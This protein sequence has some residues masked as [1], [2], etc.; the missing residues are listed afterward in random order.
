MQRRCKQGLETRNT[1]QER[2][3]NADMREFGERT[4]GLPERPLKE[5]RKQD[6]YLSFPNLPSLVT[7]IGLAYEK[8]AAT[9][10]ET[11][12]PCGVREQS[13]GKAKKPDK[14][15]DSLPGR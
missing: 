12:V 14:P 15:R 13:P 10:Q 1:V 9:K 5:K 11:A 6:V 4:H 2:S 3:A 8:P 7:P